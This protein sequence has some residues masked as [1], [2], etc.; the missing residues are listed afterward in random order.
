M[1]RL[2]REQIDRL[3]RMMDERWARELEEIRRVAERVR[4]ERHR[5]ALA[6]VGDSVDQ[7]LAEIATLEDYA[8]VRQDIEDVRDIVAARQRI[9][10]GTYGVCTDCG[11]DIPYERLLAYPTAKRCIE[12][13]QAHELRKARG[14]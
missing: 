10:A 5:A 14:A 12:C 8:V 11:A 2:T 7:A 1:A 3:N 6:G 9:Q 4:D 13:Q